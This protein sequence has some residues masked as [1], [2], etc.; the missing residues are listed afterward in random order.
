[1]EAWTIGPREL[2]AA[3]AKQ[4]L[5]GLAFHPSFKTNRKFYV[6]YTNTA[7]TAGRAFQGTPVM[8]AVAD[9][10]VGRIIHS[11][12][13]A[14][15]YGPFLPKQGGGTALCCGCS[16]TPV[17]RRLP[18]LTVITFLLILCSLNLISIKQQS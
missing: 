16:Q 14:G 1:M 18:P 13:A 10:Y 8:G 9:A 17:T 4:G 2:H 7:G 12:N 6:S 5:L 11:G 3:A 15:R